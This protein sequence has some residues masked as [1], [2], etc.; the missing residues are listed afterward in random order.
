MNYRRTSSN[1]RRVRVSSLRLSINQ[2]ILDVISANSPESLLHA[3]F[4]LFVANNETTVL[5]PGN[6]HDPFIYACIELGRTQ[7]VC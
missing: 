5:V 3:L 7:P 1:H 4:D 6:K 2:S